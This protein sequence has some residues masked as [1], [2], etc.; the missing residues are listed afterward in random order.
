MGFEAEKLSNQE[1]TKNNGPNQLFG[2]DNNF[3]TLN[4]IANVDYDH[5][6]A[7][8]N[9]EFEVNK[10]FLNNPENSNRKKNI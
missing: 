2:F 7:F 4:S 1:N 10:I 5:V 8:E 9:Q 6:S 3:E